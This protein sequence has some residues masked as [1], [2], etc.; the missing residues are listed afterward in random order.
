MH[1]SRKP[2]MSAATNS[3]VAVTR[4][5]GEK[6]THASVSTI[7]TDIRSRRERT[8]VGSEVDDGA[9]EVLGL[10]DAGHR[11]EIDPGLPAQERDVSESLEE[12]GREGGYI[13]EGGLAVEDDAREGGL[14]RR[15]S[16][17][18]LRW[19]RGG[20]SRTEGNAQPCIQAK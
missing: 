4:D 20:G 15:E 1:R 18:A 17:W 16:M 2:I 5:K 13:L 8:G 19:G 10:A 6:E 12:G 9:L 7:D 14:W 11:S 3:S